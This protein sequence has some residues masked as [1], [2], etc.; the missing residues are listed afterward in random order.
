MHYLPTGADGSKL[1]TTEILKFHVKLTATHHIVYINTS[2]LFYSEV[3]VGAPAGRNKE[4]ETDW[5][6]S[7]SGAVDPMKIEMATAELDMIT[8]VL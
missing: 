5:T 4:T 2:C 3:E 1:S 6:E 7:D 8:Y